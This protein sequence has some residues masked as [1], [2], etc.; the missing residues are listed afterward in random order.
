MSLHQPTTHDVHPPS[1]YA[2]SPTE[3]YS[4]RSAVHPPSP[5]S[6]S[7]TEPER[8]GDSTIPEPHGTRVV[9]TANM[10]RPPHG[11]SQWIFKLPP[12]QRKASEGIASHFQ[13]RQGI[14]DVGNAAER[15]LQPDEKSLEPG[16]RN[17]PAPH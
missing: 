14:R 9:E 4:T 13:H 15:E 1:P 17:H 11:L 5:G 8:G 6:G 2:S 16:P 12:T 3:F 10:R 7:P